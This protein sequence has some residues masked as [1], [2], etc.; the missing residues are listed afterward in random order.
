MPRKIRDC[1]IKKSYS[2]PSIIGVYVWFDDESDWNL[3]FTYYPDEL[4]FDKD[5]LIGLSE[6]EALDLHWQ[7]DL[8]YFNS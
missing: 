2:D 3:L 4:T 5:E 6:N 7:R 8:E 1:E